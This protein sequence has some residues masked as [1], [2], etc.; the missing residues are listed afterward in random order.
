MLLVAERAQLEVLE[1]RK[2]GQAAQDREQSA[3]EQ[4]RG[5]AAYVAEFAARRRRRRRGRV[6]LLVEGAT[7]AR[8]HRAEL[9]LEL[10]VHRADHERE[11]TL[12]PYGRYLAV[13]G[14]YEAQRF[15]LHGGGERAMVAVA[16]V[17]LRVDEQDAE[18]E[19]EM[20]ELQ[21]D[22]IARSFG[23]LAL[24]LVVEVD[25]RGHHDQ[26]ERGDESEQRQAVVQL[27][28][29]EGRRDEHARRQHGH[30]EQRVEAQCDDAR[31]TREALHLGLELREQERL[32]AAPLGVEADRDGRVERRLAEDFGQ[33]RAV[34]VVAEYAVFGHV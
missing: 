11:R 14:E 6:A 13:L 22:A 10:G 31:Q 9:V 17:L 5:Y 1:A 19:L 25:A 20:V 16:A 7:N 12:A 29:A 26:R 34:Q 4:K 23:P 28:V 30:D 33:R 24:S 21:R 2:D 32:A 27:P 15:V 18:Q 3:H 8:D